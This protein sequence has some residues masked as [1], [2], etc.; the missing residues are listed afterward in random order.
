ME[1]LRTTGGCDLT[2]KAR[3]GKNIQIAGYKLMTTLEK[4]SPQIAGHYR[5]YLDDIR[6]RIRS[7]CVNDGIDPNKFVFDKLTVAKMKKQ[8]RE[9]RNQAA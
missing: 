8:N 5:P 7:E 6:A 3:N 9:D 4:I 1:T 2:I